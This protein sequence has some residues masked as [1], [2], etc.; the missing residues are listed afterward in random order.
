MGFY[1]LFN[2]WFLVYIVWWAI[3][4]WEMCSI[5]VNGIKLRMFMRLLD[6]VHGCDEITFEFLYLPSC[7]V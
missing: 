3:T 7:C 6:S 1:I 2:A 5:C 4:E